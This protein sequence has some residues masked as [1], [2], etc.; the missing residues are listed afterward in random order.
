MENILLKTMFELP[1]QED[2]EE[3]VVDIGSIKGQNDPLI[4]HSKNAKI[5]K[6]KTSAA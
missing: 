5:K 1:G 2:I 3:V 6:E 4:I